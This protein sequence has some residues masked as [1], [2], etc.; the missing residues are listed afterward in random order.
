MCLYAYLMAIISLFE[1]CLTAGRF[2][3]LQRSGTEAQMRWWGERGKQISCQC[4]FYLLSGGNFFPNLHSTEVIF[5]CI[6]AVYNNHQ[7]Q[8]MCHQREP[9]QCWSILLLIKDVILVAAYCSPANETPGA[10]N[11][12]HKALEKFLTQCIYYVKL[13]QR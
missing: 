1:L 13:C 3:H 6:F 2:R 5:S 10:Y 4:P 8:F 12:R 11:T 7:T 9:T